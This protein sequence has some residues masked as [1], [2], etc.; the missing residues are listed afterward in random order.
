MYSFPNLE[1]VCCSMSSPKGNQPWLFIGRSDAEAETP[2]LWPPDAKNWLIWKDPD[3]GKIEGSRRGQQR[4][5]WW[6]AS[7]SDMSL[8]K[9]QELVVDME[10]WSAAVH[11]VAKSQT[12][13][14]NWTELV[15]GSLLKLLVLPPDPLPPIWRDPGSLLP[16]VRKP[17]SY[18]FLHFF[19]D[20]YSV[21]FLYNALLYYNRICSI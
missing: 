4:V 13:L 19:C 10:A 6:M 16:C 11:G 21:Q 9:L 5:R 1:S 2:I 3:A 8:S 7:P 17:F 15:T 20:A 14:S 18:F 12:R